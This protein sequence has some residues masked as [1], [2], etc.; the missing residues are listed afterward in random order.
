[1]CRLGRHREKGQYIQDMTDS[2]IDV[3]G[4]RTSTVSVHLRTVSVRRGTT[5]T[6]DRNFRIEVSEL[7]TLITNLCAVFA[8][9]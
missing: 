9:F 4:L 6:R 7:L 2:I 1:M 5:F 8:L 3:G